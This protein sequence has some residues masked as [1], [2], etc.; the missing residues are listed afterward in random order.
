MKQF[1]YHGGKLF[2]AKA[3]LVGLLIIV[4][5]AA[6]A[7]ATYLQ[8]QISVNGTASI[9]SIYMNDD[10]AYEQVVFIDGEAYLN[11]V[12]QNGQERLI[13]LEEY[14]LSQE[15]DWSK[16]A[17]GISMSDVVRAL[18]RAA[19]YRLGERD[20]IGNEEESILASI[21]AIAHANLGEFYKSAVEPI[22]TV[23]EQQQKSITGNSYEIEALYLTLEKSDPETYCESRMEVI[24]K[25][26]LPSVRCGLH[27][28]RCYNGDLYTQEGQRDFCVH[29]DNDKEYIPCYNTLGRCGDL[30]TIIVLPSEAKSYTPIVLTFANSGIMDLRPSIKVEAQNAYSYEP[31]YVFEEELGLFREGERKTVEVYMDNSRLDANKPYLLIITLSSGRKD[32]IERVDYTIYPAGTFERSGIFSAE[33][34]TARYKRD[35]EF[36]GSYKNTAQNAYSTRLVA[37]VFLDGKRID[38]VTGELTPFKPGEEKQMAVSY[39]PLSSGS[40]AVLLK[41]EG[42]DARERLDFVIDE[43]TL[44][45]VIAETL[46][47]LPERE[48]IL[49]EGVI[50]ANGVTVALGSFALIIA[51]ISTIMYWMR[52]GDDDEDGELY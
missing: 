39:K 38:T 42:T 28:K 9:F 19:K 33:M 43:P 36:T 17:R 25:Y 7:Q 6:P 23:L 16:D 22:N 37:E 46:D 48:S 24:R 47:N 5:I 52:R 51:L 8:Q 14:V 31:I 20:H 10:M 11:V 35:L 4:F 27:S 30:E 2:S 13:A 44:K 49:S 41:A 18:D 21:E 40:Y 29:T 50:N 45:E 32:V 12:Y 1:F 26:G 15:K 34:G 3:A